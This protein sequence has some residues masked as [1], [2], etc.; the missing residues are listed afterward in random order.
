MAELMAETASGEPDRPHQ[1]GHPSRFAQVLRLS[2]EL[3]LIG[4]AVLYVAGTIVARFYYS[5]FDLVPSQVGLTEIDLMMI[6]VTQLAFLASGAAVAMAVVLAVVVVGRAAAGQRRGTVRA[7]SASLRPTNSEA[8][9]WLLGLVA[10][11]LLVFTSIAMATVGSAAART[12]AGAPQTP[13]LTPLSN[14][15]LVQIEG[16]GAPAGQCLVL[17]G[18]VDGVWLLWSP[19]EQQLSR[20]STGSA[21]LVSCVR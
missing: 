20:R 11:L 10:S 12:Y 14:P 18:T 7:I 13:P 6:A 9:F 21:V 16:A 4:A 1:D 5:I 8:A 2:A 3:A 19:V 15:S 17:L